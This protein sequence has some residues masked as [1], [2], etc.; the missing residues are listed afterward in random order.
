M[1]YFMFGY[2]VGVITTIVL[3]LSTAYVAQKTEAARAALKGDE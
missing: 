3:I 2:L 1:E